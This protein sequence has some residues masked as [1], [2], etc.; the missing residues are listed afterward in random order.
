GRRSARLAA[1]IRRQNVYAFFR[2]ALVFVLGLT[3][4]QQILLAAAFPL[5]RSVGGLH[6]RAVIIHDMA[7]S[8]FFWRP[9]ALF[10]GIL[11]LG[12][13]MKS[14]VE[15]FAL[16]IA[17]R[18]SLGEI[19]LERYTLLPQDMAKYERGAGHPCWI[20]DWKLYAPAAAFLVLIFGF[21]QA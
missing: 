17:G 4:T 16:Y 11:A 13:S 14:A 6:I 2:R 7:D 19:P 12:L 18:K 20:K 10:V 21:H 5:D 9:A 3:V 15:Q 8:P 1:P